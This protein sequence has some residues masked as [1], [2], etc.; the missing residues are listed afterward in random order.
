MQPMDTVD[1]RS[2]SE[3]IRECW[4]VHQTLRRLGFLSDNIY[5]SIGKDIRY[6]EA[7]ACLFVVL[8]AQGKEFTVTVG[9]YPKETQAD[10]AV[11]MWTDFVNLANN[12][13]FDKKN[14]DEIYESS[15]VFK[16]CV[17]FVLALHGKGIKPMLE[18]S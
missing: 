9:V 8:K 7:E 3:D 5:I 2:F 6:P 13:E 1:P 14:L 18:W 12:G 16:N 10:F 17:Q 15:H 4:A 11:D